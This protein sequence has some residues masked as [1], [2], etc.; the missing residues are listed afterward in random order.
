MFKYIGIFAVL[1]FVFFGLI[2]LG[3]MAFLQDEGTMRVVIHSKAMLA[4]GVGL[5]FISSG[6]LMTLL[7][8]NTKYVVSGAM[9]GCVCML[10]IMLWDFVS[11]TILQNI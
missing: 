8:N 7:N 3:A 4:V 11:T 2:D 6:G 9:I 10:G 5:L 1:F